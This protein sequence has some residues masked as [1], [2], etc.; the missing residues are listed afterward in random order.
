MSERTV[1]EFLAHG[2]Q[3][4]ALRKSRNKWEC[5][6]CDG[7]W[8]TKPS[9]QNSLFLFCRPNLKYEREN[10]WRELRRIVGDDGQIVFPMKELLP[11]GHY[12]IIENPTPP[13][14]HAKDTGRQFLIE[15]PFCGLTHYHGRGNGHRVAHCVSRVSVNL[16]GYIL[17]AAA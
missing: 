8:R 9:I 10:L 1:E 16:P 15:C 17:E 11:N 7:T 6:H 13:V 2:E 5:F 3:L 12:R 14:V 4:R